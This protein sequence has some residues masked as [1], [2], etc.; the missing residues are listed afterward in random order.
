MESFFGSMNT[1]LDNGAVFET[2]REAQGVIFRFIEG[3]YNRK[4]LHSAIGYHSPI[5]CEQ[6][7]AAA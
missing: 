6:I 5:E 1:E 2:P 7:A 3:F 4:R